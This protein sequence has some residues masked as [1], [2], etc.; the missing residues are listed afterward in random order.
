MNPMTKR[1]IFATLYIFLFAECARP[2]RAANRSQALVDIIVS[3]LQSY[4]YKPVEINDE[5]SQKIYKLYLKR[6]DY[7]KKFL[8]QSDIEKL[9]NFKNSIDNDIE[10]G[11]F[12]FLE[13]AN[14]I[15]TKRI[16]EVQA[17]Y[18]EI[19]KTNFNFNKN[20]NL[21]ADAEKRTYAI[22]KE[23]LKNRWRKIIKYEILLE[24]L[25][26]LKLRQSQRKYKSLK[27]THQISP[28]I[29]L[30]SKAKT[31][32]KKSLELS[33]KRSFENLVKR[34]DDRISLYV[35]AIANVYDPHTA[36]LAPQKKE[37]FDIA[38]SGKL[39]GIGA[40]LRE[41]GGYIKVVRIVPGS[42]SWRQKELKAEDII[43]KVGQGN[44]EPVSTV[45]MRIS[46]AV[47]L[48]RGKKG[49]VVSLTVQKPEGSISVI[50][51]IR[52]IVVVEETYA[53]SA[54][55]NGEKKIGY[56]FLPKFYRDFQKNSRSSANDVAAELKKLKKNKVDG[57]ILD[58]RNNGGGA[59]DDAVKMSGLFIESGPIVQIKGSLGLGKVLEDPDPKVV[60][61][62]PVIVLINRFSASA[63]EI[64]AAALQDYERAVIVGTSGSFGK[65]TVQ[66]LLNLDRYAKGAAQRYAPF[67][68]L[69]F[70]MQ[71]FYR[72]NGGS[73]QYR[74]VTPDILLPDNLGYIKAG[75]KELD[76][77][78]KWDKVK[79]LKYQKWKKSKLKLK[80]LAEKSKARVSGDES[81]QLIKENVSHLKKR[82]EN[83]QQNLQ[84][85]YIVQEQDDL[86]EEAKKI[87][88]ALK[89]HTDLAI[90]RPMIDGK[91]PRF[92]K[93]KLKD[94][95]DWH[96]QIKKDAYI[97]EGVKIMEYILE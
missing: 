48:I 85:K 8:L 11:K 65:G 32:V 21:Q 33:L 47:K 1:I 34:E 86:S 68:A 82:R 71:K 2:Q 55:I 53:K 90:T 73:T 30:L 94:I 50:K 14:E 81:F 91:A 57:V 20:E 12:S 63:S 3:R 79:A 80:A 38:M 88:E 42:A 54:I 61:D 97:Y 45:G 84:I 87:K 22:S 15:V 51:I 56:I 24:Y 5:L 23:N 66:N 17:F 7:D 37:D 52:D 89:K 41:E 10:D 92:N 9:N 60:F 16:N 70:T 75:E 18:P 31:K 49:S 78:M 26:N 76:Y 83:T 29:V 36:Y 72:I 25:N 4:H 19:V 62:K 35:N 93:D 40:V 58:L 96:T 59:L 67:G 46:D 77:S 43:L 74:G 95:T 13:K 6:V 28:R 44:R 39:E 27:L 64:L 69:K